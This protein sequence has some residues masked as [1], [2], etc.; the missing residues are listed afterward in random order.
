MHRFEEAKSCVLEIDRMYAHRSV[1]FD[2]YKESLNTENDLE[3]IEKIEE[4]K[5]LISQQLEIA[6]NALAD[7][8]EKHH[9]QSV[10]LVQ[11]LI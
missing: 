2:K 5:E 10:K 11:D 4:K 6:R 8:K 7:I 9:Q 3:E 1:T